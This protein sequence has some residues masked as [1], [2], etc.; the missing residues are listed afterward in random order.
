MTEPRA[1]TGRRI[2]LV[3]DDDNLRRL[4]EKVLEP[5]GYI[6][7]GVATGKEALE[8]LVESKPDLILL[9]YV[10]PDMDGLL[11]LEL[12]RARSSVNQTPIIC[13]TGM[14]DIPTKTKA[15]ETGA[16]DYVTKPFDVRELAARVGTHIRAKDQ[17]ETEAREKE[18]L[19]SVAKRAQQ[20]A[21]QRC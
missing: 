5:Y 13:L 12:V 8:A 1:S 6:V 3:D 14:T 20:E 21:E 18:R 7:T 16:I 2:L 10:L 9:D 15:L 11:L 19:A 17:G 4:V